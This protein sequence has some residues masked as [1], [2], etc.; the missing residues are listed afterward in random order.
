MP[1]KIGKNSQK[2]KSSISPLDKI[3]INLKKWKTTFTS[4]NS[5]I[6]TCDTQLNIT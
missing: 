2:L 6:Y 3:A 5:A 1:Q 4:G